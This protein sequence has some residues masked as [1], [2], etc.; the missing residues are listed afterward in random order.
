MELT[1]RGTPL[2]IIIS[3]VLIKPVLKLPP[4]FLSLFLARLVSM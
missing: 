1:V 2:H 3:D 4:R